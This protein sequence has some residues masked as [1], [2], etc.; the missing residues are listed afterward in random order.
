MKLSVNSSSSMGESSSLLPS[1]EQKPAGK[2]KKKKMMNDGSGVNPDDKGPHFDLSAEEG[3]AIKIS[4]SGPTSNI[5]GKPTAA[6]ANDKLK[7]I[8]EN[9]DCKVDFQQELRAVD[10][11]QA[12]TTD[13]TGS[14]GEKGVVLSSDRENL[15][16]GVKIGPVAACWECEEVGS[17]RLAGALESNHS[18]TSSDSSL[19]F[20]KNVSTSAGLGD[21]TNQETISG[22]PDN[23]LSPQPNSKARKTARDKFKNCEHCH[24]EISDKIRV[25]SACK[26]VA[27]CDSQCQKEH[28]KVHK[29]VCTYDRKKDVTG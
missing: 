26:K 20:L 3:R 14:G 4:E 21:I 15:H 13:M 19:P 1:V 23:T 11:C 22:L 12:E 29:Q 10:V 8:H 17:N 24:S 16:D 18:C 7:F 25:C 5:E 27:Y 28:W 9:S 2:K 6:P